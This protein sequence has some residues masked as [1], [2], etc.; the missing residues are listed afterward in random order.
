MGV[1]EA[2]GISLISHD[3]LYDTSLL[4]VASKTPVISLQNIIII[5]IMEVFAN[6]V[7]YF[8][9]GICEESDDTDN[10]DDGDDDVSDLESTAPTPKHRRL[11]RE[12]ALE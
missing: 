2:V 7:I 6:I 10:S 3:S 1:F 4:S 5:I 11:A 8:I 9:T 12:E